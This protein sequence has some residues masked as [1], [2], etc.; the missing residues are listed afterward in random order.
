M[1]HYFQQILT[2]STANDIDTNFDK[3]K[4]MVFGPPSITTNISP[5]S[6][7]SGHIK[8]ANSMKR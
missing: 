4:E 3:T 6:F 5:L 8:G 7:S 2:W 1:Q